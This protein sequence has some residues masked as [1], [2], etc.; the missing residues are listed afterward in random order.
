MSNTRHLR[1]RETS[2]ARS[3]RTLAQRYACGH[4]GA[5]VHRHRVHRAI[6]L[7]DG[8]YSG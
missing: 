1:P 2:A 6:L 4:C 5:R 7:L 8:S 3:T